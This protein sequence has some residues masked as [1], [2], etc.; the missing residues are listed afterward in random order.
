[1][2]S[3]VDLYDYIYCWKDYRKEAELLS[4]ML[5]RLGLSG[6]LLELACGT[7]KYIS[8]LERWDCTGVDL[9]FE[10]L[11]HAKK[12]APSAFLLHAN[13]KQTGL[14]RKFDVIICLFGGI[15]YLT[16]AELNEAIAHWSSLLRVGGVLVIEPWLE[17][18][19]IHFGVPFLHTYVADDLFVSRTV[20][21]QKSKQ[22]C[23]L[24]FYFLVLHN[25]KIQHFHTTDILHIH[26]KEYLLEVI[27]ADNFKM[28]QSKK[29]FLQE[30]FLFF[31]E[32]VK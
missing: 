3:A 32:K 25:K 16:K 15:S 20:V 2:R 24:E 23:V 26:K 7:G 17:E 19:Q 9:C 8:H 28:I 27:S 21:P 30:S 31:F 5:Y 13:M 4:D 29:G 6:S 11:E 22:S 12:N 10:S 1:M 18:E 14:D